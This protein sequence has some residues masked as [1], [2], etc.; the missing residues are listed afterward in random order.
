[1]VEV[2]GR[3]L[4]MLFVVVRVVSVLDLPLPCQIGASHLMGVVLVEVLQN[5]CLDEVRVVL[6]VFL[7]CSRLYRSLLWC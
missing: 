2:G 4:T 5:C 3:C 1:M 7:Q 6:L